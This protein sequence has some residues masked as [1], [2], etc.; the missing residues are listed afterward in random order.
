VIIEGEPAGQHTYTS[1]GT[2]HKTVRRF[3]AQLAKAV[4]RN[5]ESPTNAIPTVETK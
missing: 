5:L 1:L 3:S 2:I 4:E